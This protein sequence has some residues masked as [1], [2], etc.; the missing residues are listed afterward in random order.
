MQGMEANAAA[1]WIEDGCGEQVVKVDEH[2]EQKDHI[3]PPPIAAEKQPGNEAG[4][5]Q[6]E[7]VVDEGLHGVKLSEIK[8][9]IAQTIRAQGECPAQRKL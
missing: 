1:V 8:S 6:V 5:E 2:G 4:C 3:H 9:L 7:A